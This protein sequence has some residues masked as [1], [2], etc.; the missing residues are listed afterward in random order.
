MPATS[1]QSCDLA[2]F[3]QWTSVPP[4]GILRSQRDYVQKLRRYVLR[5]VSGRLGRVNLIGEHVD[6]MGYG[7]LPMA[8]KQVRYQRR[9]LHCLVT[10]SSA[11]YGKLYILDLAWCGP[12]GT[13]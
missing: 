12:Q 13:P 2:A 4:S 6:Y 3:C 8:I 7:V 11:C 9:R 1:H 5:H 10:F